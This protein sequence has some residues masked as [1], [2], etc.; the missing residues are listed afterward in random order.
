VTSRSATIDARTRELV[1]VLRRARVESRPLALRADPR[2]ASVTTLRLIPSRESQV[3]LDGH[4]GVAEVDAGLTLSAVARRLDRLGAIFPLARPLPPMSVALA[5]AALPFFVDTYVQQATAL[6]LDGD[7]WDTP[8]SPRA[9]AGPGLLMALCAHPPLAVAVRARVRVL[10]TTHAV[11]V[12]EEHADVRAAARRIHELV[13]EGRAFTVDACGSTLLVLAGASLKRA[14]AWTPSAFTHEGRGRR[15]SFARAE[16]LVAGD[17]PATAHALERGARV[18]AAPFMGRVASLWRG[19]E[20]IP[21]VEVRRG[22]AS[23][24]DALTRSA[25]TIPGGA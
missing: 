9:A 7:A 3:T 6:T 18:V 20:A 8:R 15:A 11:V 2:D 1:E 12:R 4:N 19:F 10:T 25:K 14:G 23:L 21:V 16:S 24:A 22:I 17:V 13:E 5:C